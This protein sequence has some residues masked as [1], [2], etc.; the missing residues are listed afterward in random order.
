MVYKI[1]TRY[2][3]MVMVGDGKHDSQFY[4]LHAMDKLLSDTVVAH[5]LLG[6]W[7][8]FEPRIRSVGALQLLMIHHQKLHI[9][10]NIDDV[11]NGRMICKMGDCQ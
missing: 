11:Q 6:P 4:S 8:F 9:F 10:D 7:V 3:N 5:R 1:Y 2:K